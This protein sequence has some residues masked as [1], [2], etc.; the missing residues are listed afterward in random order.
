MSTF[1]IKLCKSLHELKKKYVVVLNEV[2]QDDPEQIDID[3]IYN[4]IGEILAYPVISQQMEVIKRSQ[5]KIFKDHGRDISAQF[6]HMS[7]NGF[8]K[9]FTNTNQ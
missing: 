7:I 3:Y 5:K 6:S 1:N 2:Q 8:R 9:Y 4:C